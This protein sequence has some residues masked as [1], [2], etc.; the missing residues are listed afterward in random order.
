MKAKIEIRIWSDGEQPSSEELAELFQPHV[1]HVAGMLAQGYQ[2]GDISDDHFRG[3]W[4]IIT[5]G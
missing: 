1:A 4:E 5:D 3:W 2:A